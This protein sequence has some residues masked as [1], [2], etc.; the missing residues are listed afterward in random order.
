VAGTARDGKPANPSAGGAAEAR[1]QPAGGTAPA[2]GRDPALSGAAGPPSNVT[3]RRYTRNFEVDRTVSHTTL[4]TATLKRLSVA[5]VLDDLRTP[6]EGGQASHRSLSP[7]ELDRFTGLVKEAIGFNAERGDSVNLLNVPFT[8][9]SAP[10]AFEDPPVWRE[11]WVWDLGKQALGVGLVLL[12]VFGVL[13]P[14]MRRLASQAPALQ[15]P[16][17]AGP[18]SHLSGE[19]ELADDRMSLSDAQGAVPRLASTAARERQAQ[20]VES[21]RSLVTQDPKRVAQVV[22]HWIAENE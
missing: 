5:V 9:G 21:L 15:T 16:A 11:S 20:Q 10:E 14:A 4:P 13:R 12:L 18:R 6:G 7:E 22:R 3:S 1:G 19:G 17:L 8:A 2:G